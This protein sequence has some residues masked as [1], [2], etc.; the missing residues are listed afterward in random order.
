[1]WNNILKQR[2]DECKNKLK[3]IETVRKEQLWQAGLPEYIQEFIYNTSTTDLFTNNELLL[4]C[5]KAIKL[6]INYTLRPKWTLINL[7]FG[8]AESQPSRKILEQLKILPFYNFYIN[9]ISDL[10][11]ESS[12]P[13]IMKSAVEEVI[14]EVNR[15]VYEGLILSPDATKIR[16]LFLQVYKL[17]YGDEAEILLE[18]S[19]PYKFISIFLSDKDFK[20]LLIK[21]KIISEL[22]DDT[23]IDLKTLIKILTNK[24]EPISIQH[25]ETD[26]QKVE[27]I[28]QNI[29]EGFK[30]TTNTQIQT[31]SKSLT[32]QKLKSFFRIIRRL[33][34]KFPFSKTAKSKILISNVAN[35]NIQ[36]LFTPSE[37]ETITKLVFQSDKTK[38]DTFF[39]H[40]NEMKDWDEVIS[41]L[42]TIFILNKV[43]IYN[44]D[45]VNFVDKLNN[46]F[47]ESRQ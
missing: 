37:L 35:A 4:L 18:N 19:V 41:Y 30:S 12:S 15:S 40:I 11:S 10:L 32:S 6:F 17:K 1:M 8:Q 2:L 47:P 5:E 44:S 3:N 9:A 38:V 43:D 13:I 34:K 21:F 7:L 28:V 26:T 27:G 22:A 23:E 20:T 39:K 24:Y 36:E 16:N 45:V 31:V 29:E 42:K 25:K 14:D 33:S 46:L